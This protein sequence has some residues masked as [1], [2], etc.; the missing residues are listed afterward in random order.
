MTAQTQLWGMTNGGGQYGAGAIFSTDST[1]NNETVQHSFS[2]LDGSKPL[3]TNL[4]QADDVMLYGM[5]LPKLI[6][7]ELQIISKNSF[8]LVFLS[9]KDFV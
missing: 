3:F 2:Q 8:F 9:R 4:V 6:I 1:G 7:K 5:T